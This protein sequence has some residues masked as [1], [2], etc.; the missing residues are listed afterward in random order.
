MTSVDA[1]VTG[2]GCL[3]AAGGCL[4]AAMQTL[5][6]GRR[7]PKPPRRIPLD[8]DKE[9]P[10]FE[11]ES[12]LEAETR[13]ITGSG[14]FGGMRLD[15]DPS[16][17]SRL[18]LAAAVEACRD[19]GLD[20]EALRSLRVGVAMGTTVG[21][22]LNN[23]PFYRA[24]RAGEK[25]GLEAVDRFLANNPALFLARVLGL[26]GPVATV[27]NA[28]SSGADAVGLAKS[29]IETGACEVAIAGGGDELSR[30]TCLGFI[31][32]MIASTQPCRPFD[33][34]RDGLN[35][36][37]GAGA[38]ILET[39]KTATK[40]RANARAC[41]LGYACRADA[42]H[43][44]APHPDGKGLRRA[45][46]QALAQAR[47]EAR[48]IA[49]VNA[50]GTSTPENDRVE[51]RVLAD[52]LPPDTPV[53]STKA[54]TGHT[55]GA[56]GAIEAVFAVRALEDGK[57]PATAGFENPDP[58][59]AITPTSRVTKTGGDLALSNSLA[60]GGNNSVLL[61]GRA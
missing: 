30:V 39:T 4:D 1:L 21:C 53:V 11:I 46:G 36:G 40:R 16:R 22:T 27:A 32:L 33:V 34:R 38:M 47:R 52:L 59:C 43:P 49:L 17:T 14:D 28:C 13:E 50:H 31:S 23:E 19:A 44:T 55:L 3:C 61:F 20:L 9:Y 7:A 42:H 15:S 35:L 26:D 10:V 56:A 2:L 57:V 60:F 37:E 41:V 58:D 24:W 25:P 8:L 29:W 5:Y 54:Y 12:D 48:E 6:E 45:I 18:A 51:G